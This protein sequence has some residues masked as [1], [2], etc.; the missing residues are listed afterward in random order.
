MIHMVLGT[1]ILDFYLNSKKFPN[2]IRFECINNYGVPDHTARFEFRNS[3]GDLIVQRGTDT[4]RSFLTY[5]ITE[6]SVIRCRIGEEYSNDLNFTGKV[7]MRY[8]LA[9]FIAP[10]TRGLNF[11]KCFNLAATQIDND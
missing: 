9:I 1:P 5:T 8:I 3:T 2:V 11:R 10:W 4:S 6:D 7:T